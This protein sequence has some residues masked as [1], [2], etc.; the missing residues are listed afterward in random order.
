MLKKQI[1]SALL[2]AL[3][4]NSSAI[5]A[6]DLITGN[7]ILSSYILSIIDGRFLNGNKI[8]IT[9]SIISKLHNMLKGIKKEGTYEGLYPL[10]GDAYSIKQLALLE[11]E[12][13]ELKHELEQFL[14]EVKADFS[15]QIQPFLVMA[16][17]AKSQMLLFIEE[18]L[19]LHRRQGSILHM[20]AEAKEGRD[21]LAFN[22]HVT[23]FE[24]LEQFLEDLMNFLQD[25]ICSCP[26]ARKQYID[27]K[28]TAREKQNSERFF[29][30]MFTQQ[31]NKINN[32]KK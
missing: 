8:H 2:L 19:K 10:H 30:R 13:P 31:K 11:K 15:K 12:H 7:T 21:M 22:V 3:C 27:I 25:L 4:I 29:A 20:W 18:S 17:G 23:T 26:R 24:K 16:R 6:R 5:T 1:R 28:R 14:K 32:Y 9:I